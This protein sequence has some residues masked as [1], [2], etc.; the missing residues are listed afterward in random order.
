MPYSITM[1]ELVSEAYPYY[2]KGQPAPNDTIQEIY[3]LI[4]A[5]L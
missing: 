3:E 1:L 2:M 4:E 5:V